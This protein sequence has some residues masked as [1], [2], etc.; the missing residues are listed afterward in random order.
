MI[1]TAKN[2]T[3][4]FFF[5]VVAVVTILS[6]LQARKTL[7]APIRTET[8]KLQL[9]AFEEVLLYFQNRSEFDFMEALDLSRIAELNTLRMADHYVDTF[10]PDEISVDR[11]RKRGKRCTL[12]LSG[13]S[14]RCNTR[15]SISRKSNRKWQH[16]KRMRTTNELRIQRLF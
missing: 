2:I 12:S 1:E 3:N 13:A 15:N 7:F 14:C 4:I 6:Y 11:T 8:F 16:S 9:K 5:I 10:F